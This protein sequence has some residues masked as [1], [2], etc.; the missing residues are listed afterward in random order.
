[1]LKDNRLESVRRIINSDSFLSNVS[2]SEMNTLSAI[3]G[4]VVKRSVENVWD[5]VRARIE[6]IAEEK[7]I[8]EGITYERAI[9]E[10]TQQLMEGKES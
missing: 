4:K 10:I 3:T 6:D 1:M 7:A 2:T 5:S 8:K 9:K